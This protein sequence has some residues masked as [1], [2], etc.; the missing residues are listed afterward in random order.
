MDKEQFR[1]LSSGGTEPFSTRELDELVAR[2]G[3][4]APLRIL[5]EARTGKTDAQ[6][7]VTAPWRGRSS[8]R[9]MPVD[10]ALFAASASEEAIDR[11][12][13]QTD[14]R[15]VAEEGEP[16]VEVRTAP[17]LTDA[18]EVV[19]EQLAEIYLAQGLRDRAA[20]IYRKLSLLNPEKSIYFAELIEKTENNN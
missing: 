3:W 13:Q 19:S 15:I 1:T 17:C 9:E 18:D 6:L 11:F 10:A 5:R 7:T 2:Y 12:L 16:E 4:F 20:A 8:L 14:L